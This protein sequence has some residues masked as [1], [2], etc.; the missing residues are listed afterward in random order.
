MSN[1]VMVHLQRLNKLKAKHQIKHDMRQLDEN[2]K[3][4]LGYIDFSK[5]HENSIIIPHKSLDEI[6]DHIM[7]MRRVKTKLRKDAA[8]LWSGVTGFGFQAQQK[9]AELDKSKQDELFFEIAKAVANHINSELEAVIVHRDESAIHS[10]FAVYPHDRTGKSLSQTLTIYR[11]S[12]LQDVAYDVVRK[13]GYDI[14]RGVK[15]YER[16]EAGDEYWK[17]V[18]RSVRQLHADLPRELEQMKL[19][20]STE[21]ANLEKLLHERQRIEQELKNEYERY[22]KEKKQYEEQLK[23]LQLNAW[24]EQEK[25]RRVREHHE[26]ELMKLKQETES[27]KQELM[28]LKRERD[29]HEAN[30][31][32]LQQEKANYENAVMKLKQEKAN[33]EVDIAKLKRERDSIKHDIEVMKQEIDVDR[34]YS[35]MEQ[36][37][38]LNTIY[39]KFIYNTMRYFETSE[40]A[41]YQKLLNR[42][43]WLRELVKQEQ[44]QET[45]NM[46]MKL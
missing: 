8:I 13:M 37:Q 41:V 28:K 4:K 42:Y 2:E 1:T 11:L 25:A 15:K 23:L 35:E 45:V 6:I 30:I 33:Y 34:L 5:S 22:T 29:S 16:I 46:N 36:L 38:K 43:W 14:Q 18:H 17:T 44:E 26:A 24:Q 39:E 10:H 7:S 27:T 19:K 20:V 9:I 31:K 21:K 3:R 12:E 32:K 40:P